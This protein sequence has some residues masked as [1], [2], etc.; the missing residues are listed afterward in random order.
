MTQVGGGGGGGG[1]SVRAS[2][3]PPIPF[4]RT[5]LRDG[6]HKN[7]QLLQ[8]LVGSHTHSYDADAQPVVSWGEE[9]G[10]TTEDQGQV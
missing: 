2:D 9:E 5:L 8:P 10:E 3:S 4:C 1:G 6:L 7:A